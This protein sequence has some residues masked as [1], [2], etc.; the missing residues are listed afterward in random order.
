MEVFQTYT[1]PLVKD[2]SK[3]ADSNMVRLRIA[4]LT[5][6]L[7]ATLLLSDN[8]NLDHVLPAEYYAVVNSTSALFRRYGE[9]RAERR[10]VAD[11]CRSQQRLSNNPTLQWVRAQLPSW[12]T[13][14]LRS[15]V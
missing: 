5:R 4:T 7:L 13:M 3:A 10:H 15:A 8:S 12:S 14:E 6:I 1:A 9:W 2:P 11:V